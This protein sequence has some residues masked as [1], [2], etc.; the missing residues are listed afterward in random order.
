MTG[1]AISLLPGVVILDNSIVVS[2]SQ[3]TH[4]MFALPSAGYII[5]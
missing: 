1:V 3:C 5:I 2:L 4:K